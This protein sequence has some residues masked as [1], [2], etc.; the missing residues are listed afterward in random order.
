[1][2]SA[3]QYELIKKEYGSKA[4]WAIW[5]AEGS[6]PKSNIGDL[7]IFD[8]ADIYKL[9]NPNFVFVGLNPSEHN[10]KTRVEPWRNF[11]ST[12]TIRQNDFKLRHA[13]CG[14]QFWGAYITDL[15]V[16]KEKDSNKVTISEKDVESFIKEISLLDS[17][18]TLIALGDKVYRALNK[19]LLG[20]YR[21]IKIKHFACYISKEKYREEVLQALA[22]I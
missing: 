11:H 13:L 21:I 3:T 20:K 5:A 16:I 15:N 6:T 8:R 14:T 7:G 22:K 1:M 9:L 19:N 2:L 17:K 10:I 18:P 4:S 12:D